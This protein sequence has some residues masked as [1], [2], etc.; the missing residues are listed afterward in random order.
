MSGRVFTHRMHLGCSRYM[1]RNPTRPNPNQPR[2]S[3][4]Y[5]PQAAHG[6]VFLR[7]AKESVASARHRLAAL[8]ARVVPG[9]ALPLLVLFESTPPPPGEALAAAAARLE[10]ALALGALDRTRVAH[11]KLSPLYGAVGMG[12][13]MDTVLR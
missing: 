10:A 8:V 7:H 13:A 5:S 12:V 2:S 3:T 1:R 4:A 11:V 6:L 9:T